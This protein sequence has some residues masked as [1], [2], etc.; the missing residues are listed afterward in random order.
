M[1]HFE[2][3][4]SLHHTVRSYTVCH[5]KNDASE[6]AQFNK[7][8]GPPGSSKRTDAFV[9]LLHS[10]RYETETRRS[11]WPDQSQR[12]LVLFLLFSLVKFYITL[13]QSYSINLR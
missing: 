13:F 6:K 12:Q 1:I 10:S 5:Y 8:S 3:Q 11:V 2:V 4:L 7:C 9:N